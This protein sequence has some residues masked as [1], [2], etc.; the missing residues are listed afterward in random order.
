MARAVFLDRDGVLNRT[1]LRGGVP[2]PPTSL[3]DFDIFPGTAEACR[4]LKAAGFTLIVVTNQPDVARGTQKREI[5][6]KMNELLQS[7]IPVDDVRVCFHDDADGCHCRKPA[8][9]LLLD[10]AADWAIDLAASFMI[11]DRWKDV[12]AG[13]RAGC[14]TILVGNEFAES[15]RRTPDRRAGSLAEAVDWILSR[16]LPGSVGVGR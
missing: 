14:K 13:R 6:E 9:G 4:S 2:C 7:Q 8:T 11:G 16:G 1:M 10:A 3:T 12:E 5:V 15:E